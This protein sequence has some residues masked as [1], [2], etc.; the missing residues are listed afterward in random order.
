VKKVSQKRILKTLKSL[1]KDLP[2][3]LEEFKEKF[4]QLTEC[5][6]ELKEPIGIVLVA[7]EC[8]IIRLRATGVISHIRCP[9]KTYYI[10]L[11]D[12]IVAYDETPTGYLISYN[13]KA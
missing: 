11:E 2:I 6:I 10:V 1:R 7:K 5:Q 3:H 12:V 8:C 13:I 4:S 9:N